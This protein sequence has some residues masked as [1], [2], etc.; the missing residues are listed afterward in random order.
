MSELSQFR[1]L[2]S[3]DDGCRGEGGMSYGVT[4]QFGRR[5][6]ENP[7]KVWNIYSTVLYL[8]GLD[9]GNLSCYHNGI[10][11]HLTNVHGRVVKQVL[12]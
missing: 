10:D 8:L 6:E 3:L 7:T 4:D 11:Q 2:Y 5:A 12:A 1:W 9:Y